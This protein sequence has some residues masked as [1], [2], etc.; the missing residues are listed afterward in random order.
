MQCWTTSSAW[1]RAK[2][3]QRSDGEATGARPL[4]DLLFAG[5][6]KIKAPPSLSSSFYQ[7]S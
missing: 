7:Y 4:V 3:F 2:G 1:T 6:F 5:F